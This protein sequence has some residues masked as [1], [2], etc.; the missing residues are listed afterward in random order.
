VS[1]RG[2]I[3]F[4]STA[5][6][7]FNS[8][9]EQ[10]PCPLIGHDRREVIFPKGDDLLLHAMPQIPQLVR[11]GLLLAP[12]KVRLGPAQHS[13]VTWIARGQKGEAKSS[14]TMPSEEPCQG[15]IPT[16]S[17]FHSVRPSSATGPLRP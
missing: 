9:P 14:N 1:F 8:V 4:D 3:G 12:Q 10:G 2:A 6:I 11:L 7:G 13:V 17:L 15:W 16:L 5:V